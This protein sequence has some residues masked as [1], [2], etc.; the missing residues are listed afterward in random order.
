MVYDTEVDRRALVTARSLAAPELRC[1]AADA[2]D[3][4]K[5]FYTEGVD[6]TRASVLV[7]WP[8]VRVFPR[9]VFCREA[10][11][12]VIQREATAADFS[13]TRTGIAGFQPCWL[14]VMGKWHFVDQSCSIRSW[15]KRA[16]VGP[17]ETLY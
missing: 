3:P 15:R 17:P 2:V 1:L 12:S 7:G 13:W 9:I 4:A 5:A 6:V 8:S 16:L 14:G 11:D 10:F